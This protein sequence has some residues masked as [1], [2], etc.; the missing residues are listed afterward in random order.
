[1]TASDNN[2][3]QFAN[4][5]DEIFD[6]LERLVDANMRL[7]QLEAMAADGVD[8]VARLDAFDVRLTALEKRQRRPPP[9][10][11]TLISNEAR[12][13]EPAEPHPLVE[14][15]WQR[16]LDEQFADHENRMKNRDRND[17]NTLVQQD[18]ARCHRR[19]DED[20]DTFA[21]MRDAFAKMS[22]RIA[23]VEAQAANAGEPNGGP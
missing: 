13:P 17:V 14:K 23:A 7:S 18:V 22:A 15:V 3:A 20:R 21:K 6:L 2:V 1:M 12:K 5:A 8:L 4:P 10:P 16:K 9:F 11:V 19:L